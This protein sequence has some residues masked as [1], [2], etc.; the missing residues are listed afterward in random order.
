M[1]MR[2]F[3][4]NSERQID[5][6]QTL[7]NR[8]LLSA[9]SFPSVSLRTGRMRICNLGLFH[10]GLYRKYVVYVRCVCSFNSWLLC[11]RNHMSVQQLNVDLA[12][13]I[14]INLQVLVNWP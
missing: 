1:T 12:T 9:E 6:I 7:A 13:Q 5:L 4:E 14:I 10:N 8:A 2:A 3:N 11:I